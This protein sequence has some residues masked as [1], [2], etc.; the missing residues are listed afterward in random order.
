MNLLADSATRS[1]GI[2]AVH[3]GR[4]QRRRNRALFILTRQ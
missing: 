4:V 3:A 2:H 1:E